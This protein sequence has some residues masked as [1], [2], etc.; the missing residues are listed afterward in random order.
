MPPNG[1]S[2][3]L[4]SGATIGPLVPMMAGRRDLPP[5]PHGTH[6]HG[7]Y[8]AEHSRSADG[9]GF[10]KIDCLLNARPVFDRLAPSSPSASQNCVPSHETNRYCAENTRH[11]RADTRIGTIEDFKPGAVANAPPPRVFADI[12]EEN[13]CASQ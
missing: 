13:G 3:Q 12:E 9:A 5:H 2:G 1:R 4:S 10:L 11:V 7:K 6:H 8:P